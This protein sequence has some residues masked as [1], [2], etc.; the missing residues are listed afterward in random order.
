MTER[1]LECLT[2]IMK[3]LTELLARIRRIEQAL[4][5]AEEKK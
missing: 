5:I 3:A 4:A 2:Q 1:E